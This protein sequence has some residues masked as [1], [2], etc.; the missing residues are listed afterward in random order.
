MARPKR[1][2]DRTKV[3]GVRVSADELALLQ[4]AVAK[5]LQGVTGATPSLP[6]F[7]L[8]AALDRARK[9]TGEK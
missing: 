7:M 8:A 9:I 1:N 3:V 4:R 5:E 2:P 6:K